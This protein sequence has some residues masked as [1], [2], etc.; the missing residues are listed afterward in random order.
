MCDGLYARWG[1]PCIP[2]VEA[3]AGHDMDEKA[4][5]LRTAVLESSLVGC[6]YKDALADSSWMKWSVAL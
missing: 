2:D 1:G 6:A 3:D 5:S 4:H